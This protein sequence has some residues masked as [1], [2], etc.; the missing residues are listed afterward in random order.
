MPLHNA[1]QQP[2]SK[3]VGPSALK[4]GRTFQDCQ[5]EITP[6][7]PHWSGRLFSVPHGAELQ[8]DLMRTLKTTRNVPFT[9]GNGNQRRSAE[10]PE[11]PRLSNENEGRLG[12]LFVII[13]RVVL[14]P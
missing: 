4:K 12:K 8:P 11:A 7:R 3:L 13:S 6:A 5:A 9:P 1:A 2:D 10:L 14:E